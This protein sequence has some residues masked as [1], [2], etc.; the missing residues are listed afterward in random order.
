V[1]LT[2]VLKL[3][4]VLHKVMTKPEEVC[5]EVIDFAEAIANFCTVN[6]FSNNSRKGAFADVG[7]IRAI[8][9]YLFCLG[10]APSFSKI[11]PTATIMRSTSF[12][13]L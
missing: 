11:V 7:W 6:G 2:G 1:E 4:V 8:I 13:Y 10:L 3:M 9:S 12:V 5:D